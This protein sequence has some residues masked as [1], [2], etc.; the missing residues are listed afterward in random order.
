M[1]FSLEGVGVTEGCG[2]PGDV[3]ATQEGEVGKDM[4]WE[5]AEGAALESRGELAARL[6]ALEG[7]VTGWAG[8]SPAPLL[9]VVV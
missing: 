6:S 1:G 8:M 9:M 2:Q 4:R 3:K 7:K 5:A